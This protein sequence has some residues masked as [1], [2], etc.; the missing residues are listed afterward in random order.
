M[1]R[2]V[3]LAAENGERA[4]YFVSCHTAGLDWPWKLRELRFPAAGLGLM[5]G[6]KA[7][8]L[9]VSGL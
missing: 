7:L 9:Q 2:E 4:V 6:E 8:L 3:V 1:K 5:N